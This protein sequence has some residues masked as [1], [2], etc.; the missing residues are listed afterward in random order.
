MGMAGMLVRKEG[1]QKNFL[2]KCAQ[3]LV[4]IEVEYFLFPCL[5]VGGWKMGQ[6]YQGENQNQKANQD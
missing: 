5:E 1:F 6:N 4:K 2:A 3:H